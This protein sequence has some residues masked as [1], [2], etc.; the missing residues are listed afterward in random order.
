MQEESKSIL[1]GS[2][3]AEELASLRASLA[4]YQHAAHIGALQLQRHSLDTT[5]ALER[6]KQLEIQNTRLRDEVRSLRMNPD[7]TP[8][9][10]EL[11]VA[12]LTI[13][14]RRLSERL[15]IIE[16]ILLERNT[17]LN[18]ANRRI[19]SLLSTVD[20]HKELLNRARQ[21]QDD[22]RDNAVTLQGRLKASEEQRKM[23]ERTVADYAELVK[24]LEGRSSR[25][26]KD[27]DSTPPSSSSSIRRSSF[28]AVDH[29]EAG[30][31]G[32]QRLLEEFNETTASLQQ[33]IAR[34]HHELEDREQA[35]DIER[36]L[37]E[38]DRTKLAFAMTELDQYKAND[39]SAANMVSRY[40]KFSQN[41]IDLLQGALDTQRTRHEATLASLDAEHDALQKS[42]ISSQA[43]TMRIRE[44]LDELTE[45]IS[46]ESYGRRREVA[47][48]LRLNRRE[49]ETVAALRTLT[50]RL[51]E[52]LDRFNQDE[53]SSTVESMTKLLERALKDVSNLVHT[54]DGSTMVVG[55]NASDSEEMH[56][57]GLSNGSIARMIAS[58]EAVAT[59]V[60]ELHVETERRLKLEKSLA[61]SLLPS[62]TQT[63]S[64]SKTDSKAG[65]SSRETLVDPVSSPVQPSSTTTSH[66]SLSV[67][68]VT[69]SNQEDQ[70]ELS[71]H[72][73][74]VASPA[75]VLQETASSNQSSPHSVPAV[76]LLL[77]VQKHTG[78]ISPLV[79]VDGDDL[80][81]QEKTG[82]VTSLETPVSSRPD[83]KVWELAASLSKVTHRYD[84]I[85][86]SFKN[87]YST[88]LRLKD[89]LNNLTSTHTES[90][91]T[92]LLGTFLR[93]LED[94]TEDCRVEL[95]IR[96]ADEE[97]LVKGW[98]TMLTVPG[99][100]DD[101]S[102]R[103]SI[104][105]Q[106]NNFVTGTDP[107]VTKVLKTFTRKLED[108]EHDVVLL[109]RAVHEV[110]FQTGDEVAEGTIE[111]NSN[112][113]APSPWS[114]T[115]NILT[116]SLSRPSSP[117][118]PPTFGSIVTQ[119]RTPSSSP[120]SPSPLRTLQSSA[121]SKAL[122]PEN[123]TA[124]GEAF[125][126]LPK[127]LLDLP[128]RI[129]MPRTIH[130]D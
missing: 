106:I 10:S 17:E 127:N 50:R 56:G 96:V 90:P 25:S 94:Y 128:F 63:I 61:D 28:G 49:E 104:E 103:E 1:E 114:W 37:G 52:G 21:L 88:L 100:L 36:T 86:E 60:D 69:P 58:Q 48:R 4:H 110:G 81:D 77:A 6:A 113:S 119:Q 27:S 31:A 79:L 73:T 45:D 80:F 71:L 82:E 11:S 112:N 76:P 41:S 116:T 121:F 70:P 14:H 120:S 87:C 122:D 124:S 26:N 125:H 47:L 111:A 53:T 78:T 64:H 68:P 84:S 55:M 129:S 18:H 54:L 15:S 109:K 34:L 115:S 29:Y 123:G 13:A 65:T 75:I 16:S 98:E 118:P 57:E 74:P 66:S 108:L 19:E 93:R 9:P 83:P 51:Q 89:D 40:M 38:E 117:A 101:E 42:L 8:H 130:L 32:L 59:L 7:K 39:R 67:E 12:E 35:L 30:R 22:E 33:E 20:D 46:R 3:L 43:D 102:N 92:K 72:S 2:A 107:T 97:R 105:L 62:K 23:A 44:V 91:N 126:P 5:T 95:E 99:A 24:L 85:A